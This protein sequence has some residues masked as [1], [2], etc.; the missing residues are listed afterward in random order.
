MR[1]CLWFSILAFCFPRASCA[2]DLPA[3]VESVVVTQPQ[4]GGI[5]AVSLGGHWLDTCVPDTV[6]HRQAE[7]AIHLEVTHPGINVGCGDAITPW[8]LT[9]EFGP[10][11]EDTSQILATL[12]AVDPQDRNV[13]KVVSGPDLLALLHPPRR[14]EFHGLGNRFRRTT[15]LERR[16]QAQGSHDHKQDV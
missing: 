3:W 6:A 7:G 4:P 15:F 2:I 13:R 1:W 5:G 10:L 14:G 9:E 12:I 11:A 8:S 16:A